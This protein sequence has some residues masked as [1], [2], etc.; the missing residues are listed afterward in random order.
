MKKRFLMYIAISGV[1]LSCSKNNDFSS[2]EDH[3]VGT[4][5]GQMDIIRTLVNEHPPC[6]NDRAVDL[7]LRADG[8][9]TYNGQSITWARVLDEDS[10]QMN[11][12]LLTTGSITG[13]SILIEVDEADRQEWR[14]REGISDVEVPGEILWSLRKEQEIN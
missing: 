1:L 9:G 7:S 6:L 5:T 4:W 8:Q 14:G 13:F 2:T 12:L 3:L 10:R 11:R